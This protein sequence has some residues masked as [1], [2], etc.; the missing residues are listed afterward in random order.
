[1][2]NPMSQSV[3]L[4]L[5]LLCGATANERVYTDAEL[6]A[7]A[8]AVRV[9]GFVRLKGV[10]DPALLTVIRAAFAPVLTARIASAPDR[11]PSR[12]YAT[13]PFDAPFNDV[14]IWQQKDI[15]GVVKRLLG[16]NA[17]M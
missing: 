13:P 1:M 8:T 7:F 11:G 15:L 6:D 10:L 9:D 17:V 4:L 3:W 14:S 2:K 5:L 16:P 12:Y